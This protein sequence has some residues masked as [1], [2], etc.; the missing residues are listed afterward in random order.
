M[1]N[2]FKE[3][4]FWDIVSFVKVLMESVLIKVQL[5]LLMVKVVCGINCLAHYSWTQSQ[6]HKYVLSCGKPR[7]ILLFYLVQSKEV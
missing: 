1:E 7:E 6:K 5:K 2:N 4:L 3:S